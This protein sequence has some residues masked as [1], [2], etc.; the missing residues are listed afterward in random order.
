MYFRHLDPL[1]PATTQHTETQTWSLPNVAPK[2]HQFLR[3]P[4]GATSTTVHLKS[5]ESF[6]S[7]HNHFLSSHLRKDMAGT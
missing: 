3:M 4:S 1:L 7:V 5:S 2:K 6:K